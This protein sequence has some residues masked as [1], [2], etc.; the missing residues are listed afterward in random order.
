MT[1]QL[2]K[3][4]DLGVRRIGGAAHWGC[5]ALGVRR[6]RKMRERYYNMS[7]SAELAQGVFEVSFDTD[8]G[9]F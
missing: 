6:R 8:L 9:F 5:G 7:L 2:E 1:L 4:T 3:G